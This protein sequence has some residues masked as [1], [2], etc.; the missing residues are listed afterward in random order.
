MPHADLA[1]PPPPT[2]T[3]DL[4]ALQHPDEHPNRHRHRSPGM[5][6][7]SAALGTFVVM[8]LTSGLTI[9]AP[10]LRTTF[11]AG[12]SGV[13]WVLSGFTLAFAMLSLTG[14]ALSDRFGARRVFLAGLGVFALFNLVAAG[15]PHLAVVVLGAFGQGIGAALVLP[16]A[17]SLIRT[18]YR[19]LPG[20]LPTAIG[21]WAG[22][23]ALGAAT[24]PVVCGALV[25]L[26]S[27]RFMFVLVGVL[28]VA[29]GLIGRPGLPPGRGSGAR[30]DLPG[31]LVMV[32][33]LGTVTF[34]AHEW[35]ALPAAAIAAGMVVAAASAWL[36]GVVERRAAAPML[37]LGQ[38][39]DAAFS[40]NA[41]VTVIGSGAFFGGLYILS[42]SFQDSL[43]MSA[44]MAGV[45]LLPLAGGNVLAALATGRVSGRLG[46]RRAMIL[47]SG[48]L[49][50]ALTA[51]AL[52]S[53]LGSYPA[54]VA[55]LVVAGLGWGLLVPTTSAAGLARAHAG[56][57][58]V[59]AGLTS[60]GRQLGAALAAATLLPLGTGAGLWA[61][62]LVGVVSLALA[63]LGV[64]RVS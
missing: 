29:F 44:F 35:E 50:A 61:A 17:L 9:A 52:V 42:T 11:H 56:R 43:G 45:A 27:W 47:A 19:D 37:P 22:G 15:A 8:L 59:A 32:V 62:V 24:G 41:A 14:G 51:L 4:P 1:P 31:L 18:A 10:A 40:A 7:A 63:A 60:G 16:S 33:L 21:I 39:R 28:A 5:V 55:P 23:N 2:G 54:L 12:E 25:S 13:G 26:F 48:L 49:I 53:G 34:L 20:R 57:E 64:R 36:F 30:L 6:L 38:L 46:V 58:G 3:R